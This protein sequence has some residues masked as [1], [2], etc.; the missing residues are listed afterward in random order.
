[1][2]NEQLKMQQTKK[3][4]NFHHIR[5]TTLMK[6]RCHINNA[7]ETDVRNIYILSSDIFF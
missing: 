1:M 7:V 3:F 4:L 6:R 5:L 2:R